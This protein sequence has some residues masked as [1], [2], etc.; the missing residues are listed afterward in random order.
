STFPLTNPVEAHN[1][2]CIKLQ[3]RRPAPSSLLIFRLTLGLE[4][5]G[6]SLTV[7]Q[8]FFRRT[9]Q[10]RVLVR[11]LRLTPAT[12]TFAQ[13]WFFATAISGTHRPSDCRLHPVRL[14]SLLTRACSG[15]ESTL[16]VTSSMVRDSKFQLRPTRMAA[17]GM[18]ILPLG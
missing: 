9:A 5:V 6:S 3:A 18:R 14:P 11:S 4:V 12:F 17:T 16:P 1:T 13:M 10:Q 8:I 15:P 7:G 2:V